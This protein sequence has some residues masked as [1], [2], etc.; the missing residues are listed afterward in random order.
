[1][2]KFI[3]LLV[4][5]TFG[6]VQTG[7]TA[8][9]PSQSE[10]RQIRIASGLINDM[11]ECSDDEIVNYRDQIDVNYDGKIDLNDIQ[12]DFYGDVNGDEIPEAM[13]FAETGS[14]YGRSGWPYSFLTKKD[15][16]WQEISGH[17]GEITFLKTK[18]TDGYPDILYGGP[19]FC[20][21][22]GRYDGV[23]YEYHRQVCRSESE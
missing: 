4:L 14:C 17:N 8:F 20:F 22:V 15:G 9:E 11:V 16:Y 3:L 6:F 18:G 5:L 10:L 2:Q 13:V 12:L 19:G 23:S 21:G 1:M 7:H